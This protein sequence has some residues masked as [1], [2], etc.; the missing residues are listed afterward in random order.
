[1]SRKIEVED[2][3]GAAQSYLHAVRR[4]LEQLMGEGADY[5]ALDLLAMTA[6]ERITQAQNIVDDLKE[7]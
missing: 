7:G 4:M 2:A 1:M 5:C 3:L 6:M